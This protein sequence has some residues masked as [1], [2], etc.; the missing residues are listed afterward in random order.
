[1]ILSDVVMLALYKRVDTPQMREGQSLF[2][3]LAEINAAMANVIVNTDKDPFH[4]DE[5]IDNFY[6]YIIDNS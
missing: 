5:N 4:M 1:M 6:K 3:A 2:N